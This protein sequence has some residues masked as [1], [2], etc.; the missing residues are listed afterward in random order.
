M[1]ILKEALEID[2][3][4]DYKYNV[5]IVAI[6]KVSFLIFAYYIVG[7]VREMISTRFFFLIK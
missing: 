2:H 6:L 3:I 7:V 1:S 4:Y 5:L